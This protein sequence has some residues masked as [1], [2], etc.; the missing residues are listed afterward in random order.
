MKQIIAEIVRQKWQQLLVIGILL[1]SN[2]GIAVYVSS[3]QEL[4][5]GQLS[6][7]W[8]SVRQQ[9]ASASRVDAAALFRQANADLEKLKNTRI[10]EKRDFAKILGELYEAAATNAVDFDRVGYKAAPIKEDGLLA[11]ELTLAVT[12]NYAA[13]KSFLADLQKYSHLLVIESVA[14]ANSDLFMEHVTMDL[15]LTLYVR[16]GV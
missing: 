7:Q 15:R 11:Y 4:E 8:N 16:G 3:Y 5:F 12:G 1:L 14:F 2:I 9:G 10:P 13:V 6:T